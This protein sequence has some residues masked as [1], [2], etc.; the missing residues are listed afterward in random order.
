M[1]CTYLVF[2]IKC[3]LFSASK[4]GSVGVI[5]LVEND[6]DLQWLETNSTAG[7]YTIVLSFN[8]FNMDTL[9]RFKRTNN[10]NGVLLTKETNLK[11]PFSYSPDDTCPNR[12]SGFKSCDEPWNTY[13]SSLLLE[14]WPFPMFYMQV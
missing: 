3:I 14:D 12:Y 10:V 1:I 4:A 2:F 9:K 7:P 6:A 13:G 8:M 5:Q 11:R